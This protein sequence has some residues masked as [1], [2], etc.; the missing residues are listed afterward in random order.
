M[1]ESMIALASIE[2]EEAYHAAHRCQAAALRLLSLTSARLRGLRGPCPLEGQKRG[3]FFASQPNGQ[4][5]LIS[6]NALPMSLLGTFKD[7]SASHRF[8]L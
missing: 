2:H 1:K 3:R 5:W 8:S 7:R 6:G 4:K